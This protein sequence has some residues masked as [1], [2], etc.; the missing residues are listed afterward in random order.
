VNPEKEV[1]V[2]DPNDDIPVLEVVHAVMLGEENPIFEENQVLPEV[3]KEY[4]GSRTKKPDKR[5]A[6]VQTLDPDITTPQDIENAAAPVVEGGDI[7]LGQL[8]HETQAY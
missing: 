7:E 1:K 6:I 2:H 4:V 3:E 8:Q 5:K